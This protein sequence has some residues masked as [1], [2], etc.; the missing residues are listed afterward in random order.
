MTD[1]RLQV[2]FGYIVRFDNTLLIIVIR[3]NVKLRFLAA[4]GERQVYII[5]MPYLSN[6]IQ[7]VRIRHSLKRI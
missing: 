7:P 6:Q 2:D 5:R 1:F 4:T 3:S